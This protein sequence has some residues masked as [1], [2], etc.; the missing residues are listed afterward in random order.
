MLQ[1]QASYDMD[2]GDIIGVVLGGFEVSYLPTSG[3][4]CATTWHEHDLVRW[5]LPAEKMARLALYFRYMGAAKFCYPSCFISDCN[6]SLTLALNEMWVTG[7]QRNDQ[8]AVLWH[9]AMPHCVRD[10]FISSKLSKVVESRF[11][12]SRMPP[13][14]TQRCCREQCWCYRAELLHHIN[15]VCRVV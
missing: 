7:W 15:K 9:A 4:L 5:Y 12:D 14:Q 10:F 3:W 6:L 1:G 8:I 13:P 11:L 2:M